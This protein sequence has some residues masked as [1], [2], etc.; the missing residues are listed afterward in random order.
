MIELARVELDSC[1][2]HTLVIGGTDMERPNE[3]VSIEVIC[4]SLEILEYEP[5]EGM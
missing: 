2:L 4:I 3:D 5:S 1:T